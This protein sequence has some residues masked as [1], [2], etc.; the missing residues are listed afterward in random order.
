MKTYCLVITILLAIFIG[1]QAISYVIENRDL[2]QEIAIFDDIKGQSKVYKLS[3]SKNGDLTFATVKLL[4][5]MPS[6][7]HWDYYGSTAVMSYKWINENTILIE[8]D[9]STIKIVV[10]KFTVTAK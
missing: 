9:D 5:S 6:I 2:P 1:Y 10:P 8:M 3:Y 7:T 4:Y